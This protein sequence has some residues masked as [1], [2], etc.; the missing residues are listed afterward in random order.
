MLR[1]IIHCA[2]GA[3]YIANADIGSPLGV[4]SKEGL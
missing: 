3:L 4:R 1:P 2:G